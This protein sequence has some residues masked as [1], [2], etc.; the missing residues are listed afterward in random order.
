M[1]S[2][3]EVLEDLQTALFVTPGHEAEITAAIVKLHDH[4][5]LGIQISASGA[6]LYERL[7]TMEAFARSVGSLYAA[8]TPR[9][10]NMTPSVWPPVEEGRR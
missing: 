9:N 2:I 7:F 1:G 3:P 6:A 8:M 4:P 5:D 10:G